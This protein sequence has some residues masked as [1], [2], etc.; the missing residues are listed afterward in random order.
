MLNDEKEKNKSANFQDFILNWL[1]VNDEVSEVE[2]VY[3][4]A[5]SYGLSEV[6]FNVNKKKTKN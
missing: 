4:L 6:G 2:S 1:H 3:A 5:V